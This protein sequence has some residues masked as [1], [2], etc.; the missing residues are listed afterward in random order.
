MLECSHSTLF[1]NSS[2][3]H[4]VLAFTSILHTLPTAR[5]YPHHTSLVPQQPLSTG[6]KTGIQN[7]EV[8]D[9][10][11]GLQ[12]QPVPS[13]LLLCPPVLRTMSEDLYKGSTLPGL[14]EQQVKC[15]EQYLSK[16]TMTQNKL[17]SV[18]PRS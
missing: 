15:R 9:S 2:F 3:L 4:V 13:R 11:L 17:A 12:D 7:A 18:S 1:W 5:L 10:E 6:K 8:R 16:L 14:A